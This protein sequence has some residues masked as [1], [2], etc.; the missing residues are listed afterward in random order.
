M[1]TTLSL[2]SGRAA[3]AAAANLI[4]GRHPWRALIATLAAGVAL[5]A[6]S[7]AAARVTGRPLRAFLIDPAAELGS[8]AYTGVVSNVTVLV[9]WSAAVVACL[10]GLVLRRLDHPSA[11]PLLLLAALSAAAG[12]DDLFLGHEELIP[13]LG[14]PQKVVLIIF[15]AA[16]ASALWAIR[17]FLREG[18]WG[19]LVVA[20]PCFA[21]SLG[22]DAL[23]E[24]SGI[25]YLL[26]DGAKLLGVIAWATF[27]VRSGWSALLAAAQP[28]TG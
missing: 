18:E 1:R 23:G 10:S 2:R 4:V 27:S 22:V 15:A 5:L 11:A 7:V 8:P 21:F 12:A 25:A 19:M 13:S 3:P 26:E 16:A 24:G 14:V 28:V 20:A 6:A 17:D 9:W